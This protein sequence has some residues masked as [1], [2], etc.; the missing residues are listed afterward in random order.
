M[1]ESDIDESRNNK[2]VGIEIIIQIIYPEIYELKRMLLKER[3]K[4]ISMNRV[5]IN[6][7]ELRSMNRDYYIQ[8]IYPEILFKNLNECCN[9]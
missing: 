6:S 8:I 9:S 2:F 3:K 4:V 1:E 5:I 7:F